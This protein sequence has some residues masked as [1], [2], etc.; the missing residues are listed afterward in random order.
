MTE[1]S[2]TAATDT[3]VEK[4]S[5]LKPWVKG[6]GGNPKGRPLGSRNRL[7]ENLLQVFADDFEEFGAETVV[8]IR[9]RDPGTYLKIICNTLPKDCLRRKGLMSGSDPYVWSGRALQEGASSWRSPVLHQCIRSLIGAVLLRTNM[10]ISA[11]A[12]SLADRPRRAFWVTSVRMRREDR[13]SIS[14]HSLAYLGG[15]RE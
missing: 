13:S 12:I 2:N 6:Q 9:T 15:L 1:P 8:K 11:H 5:N 7:G 4:H 3:R 10:D 14:S